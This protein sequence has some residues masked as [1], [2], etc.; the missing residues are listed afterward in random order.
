MKAGQRRH[1]PPEA[2][3]PPE[4]GPVTVIKVNP[5]VWRHALK[6]AGGNARR[7]EVIDATHVRVR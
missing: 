6:L 5:T 2:A 7:L 3:R 4:P 1:R